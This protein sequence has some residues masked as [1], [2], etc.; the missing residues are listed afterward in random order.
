MCKFPNHIDSLN[1][2]CKENSTYIVHLKSLSAYPESVKVVFF[3][4]KRVL[5]V[6]KLLWFSFKKECWSI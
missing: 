1:T 5:F 3:N 4:I 2:H 6:I